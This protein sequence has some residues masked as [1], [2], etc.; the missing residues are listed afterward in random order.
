MNKDVIGGAVRNVV[1]RGESA[2]GDATDSGRWQVDGAID[3]VAGGAQYLYGRAKDGVG[4]MI[5]AAPGVI[6]EARARARDAAERGREVAGR[7]RDAVAGAVEDSPVLWA[8]AAALGGYA[9]AWFIHSR[10]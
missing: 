10:R 4:D 6:D 2:I 1:G 5:D 9:L 7:G 8:A 3:Q